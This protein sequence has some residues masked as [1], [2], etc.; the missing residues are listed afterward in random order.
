[1]D[2]NG[3]KLQRNCQ[4]GLKIPLKIDFIPVIEAL[5]EKVFIFYH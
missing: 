4:G 2:G 1:M 5:L 3:L